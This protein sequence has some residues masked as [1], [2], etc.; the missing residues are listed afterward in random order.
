MDRV[1]CR[2][3]TW[4]TKSNIDADFDCST[5]KKG[6]QSLKEEEKEELSLYINSF[7]WSSHHQTLD[8]TRKSG[9]FSCN[10]CCACCTYRCDL[11]PCISVKRICSRQQVHEREEKSDKLNGTDMHTT[12]KHARV[13]TMG[14]GP[15]RV[16]TEVANLIKRSKRKLFQ[17]WCA[18]NALG[19]LN[20]NITM[21]YLH[22]I[23]S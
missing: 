8:I 11:I 4:V 18:Y 17:R 5:Y 1:I 16:D 2:T 14:T 13:R 3:P 9:L 6:K 23:I 20:V 10:E 7:P 19:G 15:H 12:V 21:S 22:V